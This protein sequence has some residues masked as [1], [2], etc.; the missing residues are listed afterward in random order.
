MD[1]CS[2][3][4]GYFGI[5]I[6]QDVNWVDAQL[7]ECRTAILCFPKR[8]QRHQI[9]FKFYITHYTQRLFNVCHML[10]TAQTYT[11]KP[12]N[13]TK[14][15]QVHQRSDGLPEKG[16]GYPP[17]ISGQPPTPSWATPLLSLLFFSLSTSRA[18][19]LFQTKLATKSL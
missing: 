7:P 3:F 2:V 13:H 11:E 1:F 18:F 17:S 14:S 4:Q 19:D 15:T 16:I 6:N 9:N 5:F 8:V 10:G 12:K